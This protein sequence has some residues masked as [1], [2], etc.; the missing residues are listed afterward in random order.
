MPAAKIL[1]IAH[2]GASGLVEFDNTLESFEK[3]IYVGAPMVEFDVRK[4]KDNLFICYHDESIDGIKISNLD[5][6]KLLEISRKKGF[7]IPLLSDVI[8]LCK[9]KIRLDIELKERGY[10]LEIV[11][12]VK[13]HLDYPD[14]IIKSFY[15]S[16]VKTIKQID[17]KITAGLLLGIGKPKYLL[18]TRLLE[19]FPEY[20]LFHAKADFVSPNY[21]LLKFG[22]SKRMKLMRKKIYVWT[23]NDEYLMKKVVKKGVSALITDRPD[24]ALKLLAPEAKSS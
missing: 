7:D 22:F 23:V 12:L 3:A 11:N 13:N 16:S 19:L 21:R 24:L 8:K 4:T 15:D 14:Y 9:G 1:I 5:Y 10:E 2:R 6:D 17:K 20:R 18:L